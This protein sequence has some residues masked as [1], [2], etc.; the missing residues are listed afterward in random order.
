MPEDIKDSK[1]TMNL[2]EYVVTCA[3]TTCDNRLEA[4]VKKTMI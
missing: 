3:R 2:T 1:E 4:V